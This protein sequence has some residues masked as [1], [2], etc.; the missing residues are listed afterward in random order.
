M[1][2]NQVYHFAQGD[3]CCGPHHLPPKG[4]ASRNQIRPTPK[5]QTVEKYKYNLSPPC[6]PPRTMNEL[7]QN[8]YA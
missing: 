8:I 3:A 4:R 7:L 6:R 5:F 2:K 1:E